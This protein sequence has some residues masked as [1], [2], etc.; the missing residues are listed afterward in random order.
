[1]RRNSSAGGNGPSHVRFI[2]LDAELNEGDLREVTQAIQNAL[3]T[4]VRSP[5][6]PRALVQRMASP[7]V[8]ATPP[9]PEENTV[10]EEESTHREAPISMSRSAGPRKHRTPKVLNL[11]LTSDPSFAAY[12]RA[13][14]PPSDQLKFL[15]V[16]AW[17]K[18]NRGSASIT[19]D[20]VYT[21]YRAVN[22]PSDIGDFSAP[23]RSLK[24]QQFLEQTGRGAYAINHLGLAK[25]DKL[26]PDTER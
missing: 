2:M 10:V 12:A 26:G 24:R 7:T 22:W 1:M 19:V 18:Q 17:F 14:N 25:V 23:L 6:S 3:M 16:A 5:T 15:V 8:E 11:D 9:P 21:C 4:V 13:K 20:H